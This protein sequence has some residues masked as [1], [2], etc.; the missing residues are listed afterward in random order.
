ML[1]R[2]HCNNHCASD[3]CMVCRHLRECRGL[4]YYATSASC[5][6][7]DYILAWCHECHAVLE[8]EGGWSGKAMDSA[9][10]RGLCTSCY[11]GLM[12]QHTQ[13]DLPF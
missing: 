7:G 5:S 1:S 6:K 13:S 11:R 3:P 8:E 12:R 10:L 4:R 2:I 9:N